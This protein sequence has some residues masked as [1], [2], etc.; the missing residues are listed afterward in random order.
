[1]R[2]WTATVTSARQHCDRQLAG[3]RRAGE[4]GG[5]AG[6]VTWA[7][8]AAELRARGRTSP[9]AASGRRA[10]AM[11]LN[12]QA[13]VLRS[14]ERLGEV[15]LSRPGGRSRCSAD[16]R[17]T[18]V[19]DADPEPGS[20]SLGADRRRGRRAR[21]PTTAVGLLVTGLRRQPRAAASSGES[22]PL[23]R[24]RGRAGT[25][26]LERGP[27]R[28]EPGPPERRPRG[29]ASS[30]SRARRVPGSDSFAGSPAA[31][32]S[33]PTRALSRHGQVS[34]SARGVKRER[35]TSWRR[36]M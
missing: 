14:E 16:A 4:R 6:G 36:W 1:M 32:P 20:G 21:L 25:R 3:G 29:D 30:G 7:G 26:S 17:C 18:H 11:R 12:E 31:R 28:S 10:T 33:R 27:G 9:P 5:C 19:T 13:A 34:Q 15:A 8:A 24:G 2:P 35:S 23:H 22:R